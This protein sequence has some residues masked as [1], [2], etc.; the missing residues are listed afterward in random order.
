MAASRERKGN[1]RVCVNFRYQIVWGA[2]PVLHPI[3]SLFFLGVRVF[4]FTSWR[5]S[6]DCGGETRVH[7]T[8]PSRGCEASLGLH[9]SLEGV[10]REQRSVN[11]R[12]SHCTC[13]FC[14]RLNV[15]E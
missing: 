3:E 9:A 15:F 5:T 7:T 2:L 1:S 12:T 13:L 6:N 14:I 11:G 8:E 10:K 4:A